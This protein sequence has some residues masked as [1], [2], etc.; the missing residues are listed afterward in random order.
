MGRLR[1]DVNPIS[2]PRAAA[3]A[4]VNRYAINGRSVDWAAAEAQ[5]VGGGKPTIS[6]KSG[7][8]IKRKSADETAEGRGKEKKIN[9][10]SKKV[11]H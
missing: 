9:R 11:K 6:V 5:V 1:G 8:V 10:R 4:L 7:T 2:C 3:C